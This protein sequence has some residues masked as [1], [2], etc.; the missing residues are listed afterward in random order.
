VRNA[1]KKCIRF[2]PNR[3]EEVMKIVTIV[4][5]AIFLATAVIVAS[6]LAELTADIFFSRSLIYHAVADYSRSLEWEQSDYGSTGQGFYDRFFGQATYRVAKTLPSKEE[7][8]LSVRRQSVIDKAKAIF[9]KK[10]LMIAMFKSTLMPVIIEAVVN[11]DIV[12][13]CLVDLALFR[14]NV[15]GSAFSDNTEFG[16]NLTLMRSELGEI[17][18]IPWE[19]QSNEQSERMYA[20]QDSIRELCRA[21]R[22]NESDYKIAKKY[23]EL[24]RATLECIDD[25]IA[26]LKE[27]R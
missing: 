24:R 22:Y 20:V 9:Y 10:S 14:K 5:L 2:N 15:E 25:L 7:G 8:D 19:Q 4:V 12:D 3:I 23:P 13:S 1:I 21:N 6:P 16:R 27:R 11:F 26:A 18:K 17:R